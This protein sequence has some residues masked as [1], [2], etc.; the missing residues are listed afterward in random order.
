ME[1]CA[2]GKIKIVDAVMSTDGYCV[3]LRV[4]TLHYN[5]HFYNHAFKVYNKDIDCNDKVNNPLFVHD[6]CESMIGAMLGCDYLN[7][8]KNCGFSTLFNK[9]FPTLNNWDL[10]EIKHVLEN[11][12][13]HRMTPKH[14][15]KLSQSSLL[16][17]NSPV[18]DDKNNVI[19]SNKHNYEI[20]YDE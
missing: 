12:A 11:K 16:L 7:N 3:V 19:P 18:F 15:T 10:N 14:E 13:R 8:I 20:N 6:E 2:H 5:V 4:N 1:M 9:L 17:I